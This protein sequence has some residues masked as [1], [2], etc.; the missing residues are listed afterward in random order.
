MIRELSLFQRFSILLKVPNGEHIKD[1]KVNYYQTCKIDLEFT[2]EVPFHLDGEL[3]FSKKFDVGILPG[4][5]SV[6]YNPGGKHFFN[7]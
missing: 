6:I 1:E 7:V 4:N 2:E 5:L 3:F